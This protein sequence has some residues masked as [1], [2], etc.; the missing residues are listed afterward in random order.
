[1]SNS[2]CAIYYPFTA[3]AKRFEYPGEISETVQIELLLQ[4][5]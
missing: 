3:K 5:Q 4:N 2:L 1:V